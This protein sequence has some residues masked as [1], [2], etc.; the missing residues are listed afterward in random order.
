MNQHIAQTIEEQLEH[1]RTHKEWFKSATAVG[2]RVAIIIVNDPKYPRRKLRTW[3][4]VRPKELYRI[5]PVT[6]T[7]KI[8]ILI[9][10]RNELPEIAWFLSDCVL[11][12]DSKRKQIVVIREPRGPSGLTLPLGDLELYL[13]ALSRRKA[14]H[15]EGSRSLNS[16]KTQPILSV[17]KM[18]CDDYITKSRGK[19]RTIP[20]QPPIVPGFDEVTIIVPTV[21]QAKPTNADVLLQHQIESK[22]IWRVERT[23]Q[24]DPETNRGEL[25]VEF[26]PKAAFLDTIPTPEDKNK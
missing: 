6:K 8:A 4:T 7:A 23:K 11:L 13:N 19:H 16:P 24:R 5:N 21:G 17:R 3:T 15:W 22:A 12:R 2:A 14:S 1:R 26:Q 18:G 25:E 9:E 20:T 10:N